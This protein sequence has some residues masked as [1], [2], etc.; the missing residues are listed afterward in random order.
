MHPQIAFRFNFQ[1]HPSTLLSSEESL[2]HAFAKSSW[3]G[4][5]LGENVV[6]K[7][8]EVFTLFGKEAAYLKKL[9][10]SNQVFGIEVSNLIDVQDV[11]SRGGLLVSGSAELLASYEILRPNSNANSR[12]TLF[13]YVHIDDVVLQPSAGDAGKSGRAVA[14]IGGIDTDSEQ[15][16]GLSAANNYGVVNKIRI[17]IRFKIAGPG[18]SPVTA[19][20][21]KIFITV[22]SVSTVHQNMTTYSNNYTWFFFDFLGNWNSTSVLAVWLNAGSSPTEDAQFEVDVIYAELNP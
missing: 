10:D 7:H 13:D 18:G 6:H 15:G 3:I 16:W 2:N 19:I 11:S 8:G 21:Q 22:N 5:L 9:V 20:N 17:W 4:G 12:W 14:I 1:S